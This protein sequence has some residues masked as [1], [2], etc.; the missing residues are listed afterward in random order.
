[1]VRY[2]ESVSENIMFAHPLGSKDNSFKTRLLHCKNDW[3]YF[4]LFLV[5]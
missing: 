5:K 3:K 1:M 2:G 4:G